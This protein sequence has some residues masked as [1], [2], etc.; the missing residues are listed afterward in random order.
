MGIHLWLNLIGTVLLAIIPHSL[1]EFPVSFQDGECIPKDKIILKNYGKKYSVTVLPTGLW[2]VNKLN[3]QK[4]GQWETED[5][6]FAGHLTRKAVSDIA[7]T[8]ITQDLQPARC[9]SDTIKLSLQI[10]KHLTELGAPVPDGC[11]CENNA[12]M[13]ISNLLE[14]NL[15][16]PEL[17]KFAGIAEIIMCSC[18]IDYDDCCD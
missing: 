17:I 14:T 1:P 11:V 12:A 6:F 9:K 2:Y 3:Q 8:I 7:R 16:Q 5:I 13:S 15:E 10:G 4:D 18:E